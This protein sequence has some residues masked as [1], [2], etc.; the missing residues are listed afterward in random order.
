MNYSM[1]N[2]EILIIEL[3]LVC[4]IALQMPDLTLLHGTHFSHPL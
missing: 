2:N 3:S 1:I 4:I